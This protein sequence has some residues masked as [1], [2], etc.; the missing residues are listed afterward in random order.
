MAD[1]STED[2]DTAPGGFLVFADD[3]IIT[4]VN[5]TLKRL[6][7]RTEKH[8]LIGQHI[9][10]IFSTA[11]RIFYQ[12]HF[13]PLLKLQGCADEIFFRLKT[14]NGPLIPVVCNA[15][16]KVDDAGIYSNHCLLIPALQR[17]KFEQELIDA[18]KEAQESLAQNR[19]LQVATAD[20]EEN[21]FFLD[22]RIGDLRK[23]NEDLTQFG[24]I[25]SHDVQEPIRKIAIFADKVASE[26]AGQLEKGILQ[27]LHKI[28]SECLILR[29]LGANLERFI[30]LS[31][32]SENA[33]AVDLNELSQMAFTMASEGESEVELL[34]PPTP[35]PVITAFPKQLEMLFYNLFK[36]CIHFRREGAPLAVRIEQAVYQKNLYQENKNRYR[37]AD[38]LRI[39]IHD[40]GVGFDQKK[41]MNYFAINKKDT[42]ETFGLSFGLA[43]C[44][45]IVDNHRGQIEIRSV[46][47][48]GTSVI[49]ELPLLP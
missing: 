44:K 46:L 38:F 15:V 47:G 39:S 10:S 4:K 41:D 13:Y 11:G 34:L 37:Y 31:N 18:K 2:I 19:E 45:K 7:N 21:A 43:F 26:G 12:T 14:T 35:M 48:Q 25:I 30:S 17:S 49:I 23:I 9:E 16:R 6:L 32:Y 3:G 33:C 1:L 22:R 40:N 27:Q 5:T 28:K 29:Q 20:L 8:S 36:N 24:K 42:R